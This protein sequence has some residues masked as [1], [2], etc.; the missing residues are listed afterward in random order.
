MRGN[1]K[2][3]ITPYFIQVEIENGETRFLFLNQNQNSMF[4]SVISSGFCRY[5]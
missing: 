3:N 4:T 5:S 2:T 1:D